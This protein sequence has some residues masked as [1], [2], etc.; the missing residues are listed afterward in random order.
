MMTRTDTA[1]ILPKELV[2]SDKRFGSGPSKVR[3]EAVAELA[4]IA[5]EYL[6]NSHRRPLVKGEIERIRVGLSELFSL[7]AG[8]EILI[9][10]G[11]TTAFWDAA[12]VG[13][14]E[15]RS[16]HYVFGEFSERFASLADASGVLDKSFRVPSAFGTHPQPVDS[17]PHDI[18]VVALTHCETSTG[19]QMPVKRPAGVSSDDCLVV[20]DATSA[21]A[22]LPADPTQFDVY[23][24]APQ[25]CFG[26]EGGLWLA[27]VSPAAIDRINRIAAESLSTGTRYIPNFLNLA[28]VIDNSR[29]NQTL[30][31]P[32]LSSLFFLRHSVDW[33]LN[34]GGLAWSTGRCL[35]SAEIVYSWAEA[36]EY[37]TPFVA[38]P[39]QR[40][41]TVATIDFAEPIDALQ[42]AAVLRSNGIVDVE[43][44]RKLGRNQ[45][46]ISLFPAIEPS[47]LQIL[48]GAI[49]HIIEK[50][51]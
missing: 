3:P 38:E 2:P 12:I 13:L 1:V 11:G 16:L 5:S 49:D 45:L 29:L 41:N 22:G 50:L 19:V 30:N 21:A 39:S 15:N 46:R 6:G 4:S 27:A 24:F 47:D 51:Y 18:D 23:Y 9:S 43:S 48:T 36:S 31:T 10:N 37:A 44:Y 20:V 42:L 28:Q 32:A 25:K 33:M 35:E 14:I 17:V 8:Y 7:P 26:A 34:N 40:S